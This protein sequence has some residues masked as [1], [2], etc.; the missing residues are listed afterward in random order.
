MRVRLL[1]LRLLAAAILVAWLAT[2]VLLLVGYRPGGPLDTWVAIAVLAPVGLAAVGLRWPPVAR[3]ERSFAAVV[4][5]G[6]GTLLFMVPSLAGIL[7]QLTAGGPQTL[8]PSPEAAYPWALALAGTGLFGG[9]GVTR[10][11]L[12]ETAIRR[13]RL[14]RGATVGLAAAV[15]AGLLFAGAAIGNEVAL[16]DQPIRGSRFGPTDPNAIL[17]TCDAPIRAGVAARLEL[18]IDAA[19]DRRPLG[20]ATIRGT[21]NG[22]EFR[23]TGYVAADHLLGQFGVARVD[24]RGWLR[25]IG[26][27]W[28]PAGLDAIGDDTLDTQI[29]A[30][31]LL[32]PN[33]PAPEERG[34]AVVEGARAR[35]C[36]TQIDGPTFVAAFPQV[37]WLVGDVELERWRGE[38]DYWIFLDGQLGMVSATVT[39]DALAIGREGLQAEIRASMTAT[40][41]HDRPAIYPPGR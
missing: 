14:L 12:G 33:R 10:H 11:W 41:R 22:G 24:G 1:E 26:E 31:A 6:L 28:R 5:L 20:E 23:W 19:V 36:R 25:E 13:R 29:L 17:P 7:G 38:L 15:G 9:L 30:V 2:A 37:R 34:I 16:R 3:G 18:S 21:R 39:G 4:W 32:A 40:Q 27:R 35:H 8:L